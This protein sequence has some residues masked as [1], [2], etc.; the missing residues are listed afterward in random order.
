M[1]IQPA[2]DTDMQSVYASYQEKY[3]LDLSKEFEKELFRLVAGNMQ[4]LNLALII[5]NE[6]KKSACEMCMCSQIQKQCQLVGVEEW[7][8]LTQRSYK[9]RFPTQKN[10]YFIF[11]DQSRW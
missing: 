6:K 3:S 8:F 2:K 1:Y 10:G 7:A 5:F 9:K 4:Y 11:L